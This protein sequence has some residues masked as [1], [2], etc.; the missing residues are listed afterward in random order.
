MKYLLINPLSGGSSGIDN[1]TRALIP[2]L[3]Q[4]GIQCDYF[5]NSENL[6]PAQFRIA[7]REYVLS[8]YGYEDVIIEAPE[9]KA[10]TLLLPRQYKTHIRLHCPLAIA[11]KYD[12]HDVNQ[13]A[14]SNELRVMYK[15]TLVSSPSHALLEHLSPEFNPRSGAVFKNPVDDSIPMRGAEQKDLDVVF[16]GRFQELKGVAYINPI[17]ERLPEHVKVVLIGRGSSQ[18]VLSRAIKCQVECH[19]H[20]EG[21][22]R[23]DYVGR[24]KALLMLSKFENCSM[25]ILEALAAGTI[26]H[27]WNVG[28]NAEIAPPPL[29]N[30]FDFEDVDAISESVI[31]VLEKD[32]PYPERSDFRRALDSLR[33]DFRN[34]MGSVIDRLT[35]HRQWMALDFRRSV[36]VTVPKSIDV[37]RLRGRRFLGFSISNE[38]I[39]EMWEPVARA[40]DMDRRYVCL[41]EKGHR[42]L[43]DQAFDIE[44]K[45]YAV[46]DWIKHTDR[47]I[48][49]IQNFKPD[50]LI[51]HNGLH[52][53]YQ[54]ALNKVKALGIPIVYTELGWFPQKGNIYFDEV[55]TN[56]ASRLATLGFRSLCGYELPTNVKKTIVLPKVA[57]VTMQLEN[58]TNLIVNSPNFKGNE[59]FLRHVLS[60]IPQDWEVI[61]RPLP[62]DGNV[63]YIDKF[64]N[65]RVSLDSDRP[66][67]DALREAGAVIGL[68]STVL[69]QALDY[70]INI[71]A[72]GRSLIDN[73]GVAIC[74]DDG[75]LAGRWRTELS[76]DVEHR[77]AL[78]RAFKDRQI[79]VAEIL[80]KSTESLDA[81]IGL[82]PLIN[83]V[84]RRINWQKAGSTIK[85]EEKTSIAFVNKVEMKKPIGAMDIPQNPIRQALRS[86]KLRKLRK[87][88]IQFLK[89][90]RF[91]RIFRSTDS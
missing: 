10:S 50:F 69:L 52:P 54:G 24:A 7:V 34:G 26:V 47:L 56:G 5:Q 2:Q 85:A 78:M 72:L 67:E 55:G 75:N 74:C 4:I 22:E 6:S 14:F 64:L 15:A 48:K 66:I 49:N 29:L 68:N 27:C 82:K 65:E 81:S 13:D 19:E 45:A 71:Y 33:A 36:N 28:G 59:N 88:P 79:N 53:R 77:R 43:F 11:Q 40:L 83:A 62:L 80:L 1:Y 12:G 73:K 21:P 58:D 38:H 18:F 16:L 8:R 84:G 76:C 41:R 91:L 20:I 46:Y 87:D 44:D 86:R 89:D 61:I 32:F 30:A 39:Q 51:F 9:A 60:Q 3:Q 57:L 90:S 17:L 23:L 31:N 63:G 37:S 70:P 25:V 35:Q 42:R